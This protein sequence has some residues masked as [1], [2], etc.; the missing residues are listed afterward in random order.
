MRKVRH[1][2]ELHLYMSFSFMVPTNLSR[3]DAIVRT[4]AP[5][6]ALP[7]LHVKLSM[8]GQMGLP[9]V[10]EYHSCMTHQAS[11]V[12]Q[13]ANVQSARS[14]S[15]ISVIVYQQ[16]R[17]SPPTQILLLARQLALGLPLALS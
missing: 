4:L 11:E 9:S 10:I 3:S 1:G 2:M 15:N 16:L 13:V 7:T 6:A 12:L 14:V 8:R 5:I 17:R